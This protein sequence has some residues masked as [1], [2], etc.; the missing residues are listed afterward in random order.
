MLMDSQQKTPAGE[1]GAERSTGKDFSISSDDFRQAIQSCFTVITSEKPTVLSKRYVLGPDGNLVKTTSA[2]MMQGRAQVVNVDSLEGLAKALAGLTPSQAVT[3][4]IPPEPECRIYSKNEYYERGKPAGSYART[5]EHFKW[6]EGAGIMFNDYDPRAGGAALSRDALVKIIR[7][8]VPGL[9]DASMLWWTSSSSHICN[10]KDDLTGQKGQRLYWL[11]LDARDI[12]RAAKA[13]QTYLWA[14]DHGYIFVSRSGSTL[15]RSTLDANVYQSNRLDFAGGAACKAPLE[16]RRGE[17]VIIPGKVQF[18]DTLK[19]IPDPDPETVARAQEN[20]AKAKDAARPEADAAKELWIDDQVMH[21]SD[22]EEREQARGVVRRAVEQS[23]LSGD[24]RIHLADKSTVLVGDV[25]DNMEKFHGA[26]TCDPLEPDYNCWKQ[27]GKLLLYGGAPVLYS[28]AHGGRT[29]KL[30]RQPKRIQV[31][32]GDSFAITE[33]TLEI[34]RDDPEFYDFGD[35]LALVT[36][37]R[38]KPTIMVQDHLFHELGG[39]IEYFK[40]VRT[41]NKDCPYVDVPA[42]PP[43]KVVKSIIAQGPHRNLK[44]LTGVITAPTV[45]TDFSLLNRPGYDQETGLLLA[46]REPMDIPI[47]PDD[48]E[49][50]A[51]VGVLERPFE[52]FPFQSPADK[53]NMLCAILT[54][55]LRQVLPTSPAFAFTAPTQGSGKTLLARCIAILNTGAEAAVMPHQ[56]GRDDEETRK[57]LFAHLLS[58][59]G[60]LIWDNIL[61]QFDSASAA[62]FLTSPE[63]SDRVLGKSQNATI[64]NRT[65]MLLTGNNLVLAGDMPRRVLPIRIDPES[66]TPF[67]REFLIDPAAYCLENRLEMIKAALTIVLG[68]KHLAEGRTYGRMAS[69]EQ[70]DDLVRQPVCWLGKELFDGQYP[71]PMGSISEAVS[72]DPELQTLGELLTSWHEVYGETH[73]SASQ[74]VNDINADFDAKMITI[75]ECLT[76]L[77][78]QTSL[79]SKSLGRVLAYRMG[80]IANGHVLERVQAANKSFLWR[81]RKCS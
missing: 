40:S 31:R 74:V 62:A 48:F 35:T 54:A 66:E 47:C 37:D 41:K 33:R 4:G 13:I 30:R 19:A 76:D 10:G 71:D 15:L 67:D 28:H 70:W 5:K 23:V 60:S 59:A 61:G 6:P 8:A 39:R 38:P 7:E 72:A 56:K 51:A 20:M 18:I 29:F 58:G 36:H 34:V 46:M 1:A 65:M 80:R 26:L 22:D 17:P 68:Y 52:T 57:R 32:E 45:R 9:A 75:Q 14:N 73:V 3:Y 64:P 63:Y 69:F 79:S 78:G 53:A 16:Q 24:F 2:Q 42:D 77:T 12:P 21:I 27:T 81:V 55:A 11:V 25:L 49:V 50:A 44:R 43:T